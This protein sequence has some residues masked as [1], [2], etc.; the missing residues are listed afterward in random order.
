MNVPR[1]NLKGFSLRDQLIALGV[2]S[3]AALRQHL[4]TVRVTLEVNPSLDISTYRVNPSD[5][6]MIGVYSA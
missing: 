4:E 6:N 5:P 3:E 1:G 2:T